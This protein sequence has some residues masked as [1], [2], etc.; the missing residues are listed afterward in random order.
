MTECGRTPAPVLAASAAQTTSVVT[1]T[2]TGDGCSAC[3]TG[4]EYASD[5][6]SISDLSSATRM[7]MSVG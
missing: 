1:S 7:M 3:V 4:M 6:F 2:R 5:C